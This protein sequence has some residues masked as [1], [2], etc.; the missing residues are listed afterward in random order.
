MEKDFCLSKHLDKNPFS[1][2][3]KKIV[4]IEWDSCFAFMWD[5]PFLVKIKNINYNCAMVYLS[6][7][8]N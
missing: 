8:I 3:T 4:R 1:S 7:S 2:I 6:I 5:N